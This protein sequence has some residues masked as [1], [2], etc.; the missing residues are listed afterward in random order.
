PVISTDRAFAEQKKESTISLES[1]FLI[2]SIVKIIY[3]N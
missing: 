3:I 1:N 2:R